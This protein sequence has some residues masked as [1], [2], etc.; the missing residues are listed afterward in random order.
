MLALFLL[1]LTLHAHGSLVLATHTY[2]VIRFQVASVPKP[3]IPAQFT[4]Q[5]D[6]VPP[7]GM[8]FESYPCH[9]PGTK[10]CAALA[11]ADS[12]YLNGVPTTPG[13]YRVGI[14]AKDPRGH[15]LSQKFTVV[16]KP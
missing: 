1:S 16:V 9:R 7:P 14:T 5:T 11:S 2:A 6:G 3:D 15:T 4:F 10:N 13:S 12:V 8:V